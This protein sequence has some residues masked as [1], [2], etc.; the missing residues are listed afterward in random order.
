MQRHQ[1]PIEDT[2]TGHCHISDIYFYFFLRER[3]SP[4]R[5]PIA[6]NRGNSSPYLTQ[7]NFL[8]PTTS[9]IFRTP[10]YLTQ[11]LNSSPLPIL[12]IKA[13]RGGGSQLGILVAARRQRG[14]IGGTQWWR[15]WWWQWWQR[16]LASSAAV[17]VAAR[18]RRRLRGNGGGSAAVAGSV[19]VGV[20]GSAAAA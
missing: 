18:R 17:A 19:T 6:K 16:H 3:C 1:K 12:P 15:W 14:V 4:T 11:F 7:S 5:H 9:P 2:S 8:I 20:G 13:M 10:H